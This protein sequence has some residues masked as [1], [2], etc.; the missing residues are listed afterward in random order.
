ME[1]EKL[2][3]LIKEELKYTIRGFEWGTNR[4]NFDTSKCGYKTSNG[5]KRITIKGNHY[6]E[7]LLVWILFMGEYPDRLVHLDGDISNNRIG[8]LKN[9]ASLKNLTKYPK[10]STDIK[11]LRKVCFERFYYKDG[12]LFFK[13]YSPYW[14]KPIGHESNGYYSC[15]IDGKSYLKHRLIYLMFYGKL[16]ELLDHIDRN[17][18]NNR[19]ENI[20]EADKKINSINRNLQS[21][22]KSGYKGVS[23]NKNSSKWEAYIKVNN[24]RIHL[25]LHETLEEAIEA[26][27]EAENKYWKHLNL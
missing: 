15:N 6:R 23:W 13:E 9:T 27:R 20:R 18:L 7:D 12:D 2:Q 16:P 22:N 3:L 8:N 19:I 10:N 14:N 4:S 1:V 25:K 11:L 24:K 21:N 5:F 26:R 17:P